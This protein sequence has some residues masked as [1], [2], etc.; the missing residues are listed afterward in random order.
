VIDIGVLDVGSGASCDR[1][2]FFDRRLPALSLEAVVPFAKGFHYH[3]R[4]GFASF[5][6]DRFGQAV[7]LRIFYIQRHFCLSVYIVFF[8]CSRRITTFLCDTLLYVERRNLTVSLPKETIRKA[9]VFA[10]QH[11]ITLNRL[12]QDLLEE[13]VEQEDRTRAAC[14]KLLEIAKQGPYSHADPGTIRRDEIH[15][16]W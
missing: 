9:R 3:T 11:D 8:L 7:C 1:Q 12:V 10:A 2:Q 14:E 6:G 4:N 5:P 15:E 13:K 16:R